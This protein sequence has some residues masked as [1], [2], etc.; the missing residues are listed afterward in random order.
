MILATLT[1]IVWGFAFVATKLGIDGFS[2]PQLTA[3]RFLVACL[4]VLFVAR[5][6]ISWRAIVTIGL[7][8]FTGQF[9][10]LFFA[11]AQ[12]MPPGLAAV[13]QQMQVFFTVLLAA[14][15]LRDKPS[16]KQ[17]AGMAVAFVGLALIASTKG[18]D[19]SLVALGLAL[20]GAF[21]WAIGN[22]LVKHARGTAV[23]PLVVWCSLVPPLPALALSSV[24]RDRH[25]GL[26]EAVSSASWPTIGAVL[27][28]GVFATIFG[29]AAWGSLLQRY[30]AAVVAPFAL[31]APCTGVAA[32]A[33]IFGEAF[34][35]IRYAG[36]GLIF[37]GLAVI[38]LP[39]SVARKLSPLRGLR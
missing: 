29:Y 15:F 13:T 21:S 8:L 24:Y 17:C 22:V 32:S 27:Y 18:S 9:L 25:G 31:L 20:A 3:L 37:I 6:R 23:F 28:L 38:V 26:F 11:F 16:A 5:P 2:A 34:S 14:L 30:P 1:S 10:L 7:T 36:M 12:G 19:L 33:L 39:A 4:P 35:P